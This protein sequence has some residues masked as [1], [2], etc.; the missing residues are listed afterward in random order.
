MPDKELDHLVNM[1]NDIAL[2]LSA[3]P[4]AVERV[5]DH[6]RR[7]WAPSM[8]SRIIAHGRSGGQGLSA[9]ALAAVKALDAG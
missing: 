8:R 1:A 5:C 7:F 3:Y 9:S 4:D 6:L 2:N